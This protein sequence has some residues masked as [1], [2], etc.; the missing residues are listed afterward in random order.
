MEVIVTARQRADN[1]KTLQYEFTP[2]PVDVRAA[3]YVEY[4][5]E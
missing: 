5:I 3:V 2:S 1:V 4:T